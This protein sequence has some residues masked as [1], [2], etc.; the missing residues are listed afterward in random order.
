MKSDWGNF[1]HCILLNES[2]THISD[3][4]V[5]LIAQALRDKILLR[6]FKFELW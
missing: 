4:S 2:K 1:F 3:K 6:E 5:I